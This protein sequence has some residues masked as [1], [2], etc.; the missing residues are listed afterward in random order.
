MKDYSQYMGGTNISLERLKEL[1]TTAFVSGTS[2]EIEDWLEEVEIMDNL[3][4][5]DSRVYVP[6]GGTEKHGKLVGLEWQRHTFK[7]YNHTEE[8]EDWWYFKPILLVK[9]D[10]KEGEFFVYEYSLYEENQEL[11]FV[12]KIEPQTVE[13][14]TPADRSLGFVNEYEFNDLRIQIAENKL[15]GYY[16]MFEDQKLM[17][18]PDGKMKDWSNGLFDLMLIQMSK[19]FKAGRQPK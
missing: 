12:N 6:Y 5:G 2:Y 9:V 15:S 17:I 14:F 3:V 19:M 7:D 4:V 1:G 13:V 18:E 16:V 11:V 10:G 8:T